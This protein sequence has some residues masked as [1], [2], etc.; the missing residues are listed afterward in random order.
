[1]NDPLFVGGYLRRF[2]ILVDGRLGD[3]GQRLIRG[4]LFI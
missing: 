3:L 2:G 4:F 1:M